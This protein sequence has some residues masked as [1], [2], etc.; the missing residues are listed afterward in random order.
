MEQSQAAGAEPSDKEMELYRRIMLAAM[1]IIYTN[2]KPFL[3]M[4]AQAGDPAKG[5]IAATSIILGK[6]RDSVKGLP[7]QVIEQMAPKVVQRLGPMIGKLL[8]ELANVAGII[9]GGAPAQAKP[10]LIASA[11]GAPAPQQPV[12]AGA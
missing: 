12:Q 5:I 11:Q 7:P 2:P 4:I 3:D 9:K 10:G 8:L 6:I 1:K